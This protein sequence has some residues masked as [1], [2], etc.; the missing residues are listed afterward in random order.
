[1]RWKALILISVL[2]LVAAACGGGEV[3]SGDGAAPTTVGSADSGTENPPSDEP[4]PGDS[5]QGSSGSGEFTVNGETFQ[6]E[7]VRRCEPFDYNDEKNPANLDVAAQGGGVYINPVISGTTGF[8]QAE[9]G[10]DQYDQQTHSLFL[11][12]STDSGPEQYES[13]ASHDIDNVWYVGF[14]PGLTQSG[15]MLDG[16]PFIVSGNTIS[17]S[18]TLV[19]KYP[20]TDGSADVTFKFDFPQEITEC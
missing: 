7:E 20:D 14:S 9:N 8:A 10:M 12:V 6:I 5:A 1:M 18:M 19:K 13:S 3:A 11:S 15:E 16:P 17:G 4:A 2:A